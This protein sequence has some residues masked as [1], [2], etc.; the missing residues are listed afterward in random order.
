MTT[1]RSEES[2]CQRNLTVGRDISLIK[3]NTITSIFY[4]GGLPKEDRRGDKTSVKSIGKKE[5]VQAF[6]R[7]VMVTKATIAEL[8]PGALICLHTSL[9]IS[10]VECTMAIL[11]LF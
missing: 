6:N 7:N 10:F 4:E 9:F 3:I 8:N 1:P 2:A 5:K 11:R